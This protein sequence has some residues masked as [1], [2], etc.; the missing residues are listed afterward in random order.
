ML[1]CLYNP[2][3]TNHQQIPP[4]EVQGTSSPPPE[5][6]TDTPLTTCQLLDPLFKNSPITIAEL[7]L[8]FCNDLMALGFFFVTILEKWNFIPFM[9][10]R[11]HPQQVQG[12]LFTIMYIQYNEYHSVYILI[13]TLLLKLST[14]FIYVTQ[15]Y[16]TIKV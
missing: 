13:N 5:M 3:L 14:E 11:L 15:A 10:K 12:V 7:V 9:R 8:V 16:G 4:T 2:T 6:K 1:S